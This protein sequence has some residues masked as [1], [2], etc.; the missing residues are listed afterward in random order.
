[1][2]ALP[3]MALVVFLAPGPSNPVVKTQP[4]TPIF[5]AALTQSHGFAPQRPPLTLGREPSSHGHSRARVAILGALAGAAGGAGIGYFW[6][7]DCRCDDPGY[8]AV[9][10]LP[11]GAI[12]GAVVGAIVGK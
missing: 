2:T 5:T 8:G 7:H 10:G 6:T 12:G 11:I 4:P 3:A 9:I 1:M